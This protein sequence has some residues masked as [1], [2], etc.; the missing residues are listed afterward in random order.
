MRLHTR[1]T[2][3]LGVQHPIALAAMDLVADA[4]LSL[5]VMEAGGYAFLGAGYGDEAWMRKELGVLVPEAR[6]RGQPFGVGFITWSLARQPALLDLALESGASAIWLS[7]GDVAPFAARIKK[8]GAKLACQVQT[9]A[10]AR[11]A[12]AHGADIL[13]AQ[14]S[15]AG[16]HGLTRGTLALVPA[17]ADLAGPEIPVLA[18]GGIADGRGLAASLMLGASGVVLGT[19]F[20]ASPEAAGSPAAKER[21]AR[22]SG[23]DSVRSIV[24]DVSRRNVWP[25]RYTGRCLANGHL[26]RWL[27]REMEL[28]REPAE[29]ERYA[30]ARQSQDFEVAAVIAGESAG[31]IRE[32]ASARTIIE[33]MVD[34]AAALLQGGPAFFEEASPRKAAAGS[35]AASPQ[36]T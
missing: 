30:A 28:M 33:S 23:D 7:F 24:F 1:M 4:R 14:G 10:Y 25:G 31:L 34:G 20:Y 8:A 18:A 15:E 11:A 17:I 22:A 35:V 27:G 29:I 32:V 36:P 6:R 26:R 5:A 13:V 21:I 19:R 12:L 9:E 3:T 2:R 16:G